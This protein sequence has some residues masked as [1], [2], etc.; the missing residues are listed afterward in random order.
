MNKKYGS[1]TPGNSKK[2]AKKKGKRGLD[3]ETH[4]TK[5]LNFLFFF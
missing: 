5:Y 2:I 1:L 4:I 3:T